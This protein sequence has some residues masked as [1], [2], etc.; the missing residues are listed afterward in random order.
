MNPEIEHLFIHYLRM[1]GDDKPTAA[2][3][4]L[5]DVLARVTP[6]PI[7]VE[8]DDQGT[9]GVKEAAELLHTSSKNVYLMCLTG[10][11]RGRCI[12]CRVRIPVE[13]IEHQQ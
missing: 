4:V 1:A 12:G 2:L 3:L 6:E 5:A 11:L 10:K 8:T 13:E 9:V 7:I